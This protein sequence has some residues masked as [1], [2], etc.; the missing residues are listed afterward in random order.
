MCET[1][2]K[3]Y[4]DEF[5]CFSG[6]ITNRYFYDEELGGYFCLNKE[7][8]CDLK[9]FLKNDYE[10]FLKELKFLYKF[11][12]F[13]HYKIT[14]LIDSRININFNLY[15][16][17]RAVDLGIGGWEILYCEENSRFNKPSSICVEIDDELDCGLFR[18]LRSDIVNIKSVYDVLI[19]DDKYLKYYNVQ[20]IGNV[21]KNQKEIIK[22]MKK[23]ED[24]FEKHT[25][26]NIYK[27]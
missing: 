24:V 3:K 23:M 22:S 8:D 12:I 5:G 9:K 27:F 14:N 25:I 7:L 15:G 11:N 6:I 10:E 26:F 2:F 21:I 17:I 1:F 4:D 19:S 18:N 13:V 16:N 20:C